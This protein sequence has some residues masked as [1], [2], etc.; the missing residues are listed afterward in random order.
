VEMNEMASQSWSV[1]NRSRPRLVNLGY[2]VKDQKTGLSSSILRYHIYPGSRNGTY[3]YLEHKLHIASRG[4]KVEPSE[5]VLHQS[6]RTTPL[7]TLFNYPRFTLF[8]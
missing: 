6:R 4:K 7:T 2:T 3:P 8:D 1:R 5:L